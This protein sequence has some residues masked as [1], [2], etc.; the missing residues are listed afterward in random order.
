MKTVNV[1][2]T[3]DLVCPW[4]WVG[5]RKLQEA[6]K[7]ANINTR[8]I[9]KPFML[10]PN[11]PEEGAPK[12]GT[13]ASRVGDRLKK[14]GESVGIQ[15]TGLTDRTPNTALFH[16]TIK[17]LQQNDKTKDDAT[18]FHEAVFMDYFT[19]GVFPDKENLLAAA[20]RLDN[21]QVYELV[22]DLYND[23]ERLSALRKEVVDEAQEASFSGISGVPTFSFEN[24]QPA[25]SGAQSADVFVRYLERYAKEV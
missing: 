13:P 9:W 12:G 25:F 5:L 2:I 15:F 3:S 16:A 10:R 1:G 11:T 23:T 14:A 19:L 8:I 24:D 6:S 17:A 22:S 21:P 4:C 18:L 7:Q 20:K